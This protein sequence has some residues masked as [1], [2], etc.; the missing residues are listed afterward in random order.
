MYFIKRKVYIY[1]NHHYHEYH[2]TYGESMTIVKCWKPKDSKSIIVVIPHQ[3]IERLEIKPG[4]YFKVTVD[5]GSIVYR[6]LRIGGEIE[7]E[8]EEKEEKE[9]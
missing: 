5:R 2:V 1:D 4:T 9:K 8:E 3:V 7:H 6:P